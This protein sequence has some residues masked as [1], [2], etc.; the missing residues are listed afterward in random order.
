M[1]AVVIELYSV[2]WWLIVAGITA[3]ASLSLYVSLRS[4]QPWYVEIPREDCVHKPGRDY[5]C[6][7]PRK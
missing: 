3:F 5:L 1:F 2:Q 7:C 4:K 6:Q